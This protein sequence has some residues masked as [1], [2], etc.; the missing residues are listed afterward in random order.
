MSKF[1]F[2]DSLTWNNQNKT[3]LIPLITITSDSY[4]GLLIKNRNLYAIS[5]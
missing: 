4:R 2:S 5:Y 1:N 3:N